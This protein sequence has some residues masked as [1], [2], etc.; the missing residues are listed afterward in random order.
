MSP[1]RSHDDSYHGHRR[2]SAHPRQI[3]VVQCAGSEKAA[4]RRARGGRLHDLAPRRPNDRRLLHQAA[5]LVDSDKAEVSGSV[6][7]DPPHLPW[8]DALSEPRIGCPSLARQQK[9]SRTGG[10]RGDCVSSGAVGCCL[11]SFSAASRP[12]GSSGC[13]RAF[14]PQ[15]LV[16]SRVRVGQPLQAALDSAGRHSVA[17]CC[18]ADLRRLRRSVDRSRSTSSRAPCQTEG[19]R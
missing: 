16:N 9:G 3:L 2:P 10:L 4:R 1:G 19:N 17:R 6:H 14:R 5:R 15:C 12:R 7:L 18:A 13:P 8:S 11:G